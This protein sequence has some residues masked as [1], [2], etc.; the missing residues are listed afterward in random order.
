MQYALPL[1]L[2][3]VPAGGVCAGIDWA[4]AD[5]VACVAGL[6]GR[7]TG[8][9]SAAHDK[10]GSAAMITRLRRGKVTEVAIE[11]GDGPLVDALL[12]AGLTVVVITSRQVKNL[13]SRYGSAGAKDDRFDSF[14]LADTLRTDRA[15]LRPLVPGTPATMS[16]RMTVRARRESPRVL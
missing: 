6:A 13:R 11:R 7:V 1:V 14:V 10:A 3:D 15:R 4:T 2:P 8:R 9:F 12:A 5:H 16:L